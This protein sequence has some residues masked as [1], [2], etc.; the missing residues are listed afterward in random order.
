MTTFDHS[1]TPKNDLSVDDPHQTT[2]EVSDV[3]S[4]SAERQGPISHHTSRYDVDEK[5]KQKQHH[6]LPQLKSTDIAIAASTLVLQSDLKNTTALLST[7]P[8][9]QQNI[10]KNMIGFN[11]E[12]RDPVTGLYHL[13]RGIR[14]YSPQLMR[15]YAAD[16][17]SPFGAG[18]INSYAYCLGDPI[19]FI[20]PNG[21]MS[22]SAW[23]GISLGILGLIFSIATL[24]MGIAAGLSMMTVGTGLA[25]AGS[26]LGVA[27]A[28]TS[29]ASS[30]LEDRNPQ[31][32]SDLGW[33]SLGLGIGS[34]VGGIGSVA[35]SRL[36][37]ISRTAKINRILAA[38][39]VTDMV[40]ATSWKAGG[41]FMAKT[42][43]SIE[44]GGKVP[45][46]YLPYAENKIRLLNLNKSSK[47]MTTAEFSGCGL[48]IDNGKNVTSVA[49]IAGNFTDKSMSKIAQLTGSR[50]F[51]AAQYSEKATVMGI[52][53]GNSW[54]FFA[55]NKYYLGAL[56]GRSYPI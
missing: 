47:L 21:H 9:D 38:D 41:T 39:P 43:P 28:A 6:S 11:G 12:R 54:N 18:G 17:I 53:S 55:Q 31:M 34:L 23:A 48:L 33:A 29:I 3:T 36:S 22:A 44:P 24:G 46:Q 5:Y 40:N 35:A 14:A 42:S 51:S 52:R 4:M 15:F 19:N 10:L 13:G 56:M 25:I 26:I 16:S 27:S 8:S 1:T 20:D 50:L 37:G 49:H 45:I 7:L 2:K 30:A 32:S